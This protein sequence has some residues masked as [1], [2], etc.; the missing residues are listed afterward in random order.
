MNAIKDQTGYAGSQSGRI[1]KLSC[2]SCRSAILHILFDLLPLLRWALL[3]LVFFACSSSEPQKTATLRLNAYRDPL[4]LDPRQGS[5]MVGSALHFIL[6]EGLM[7][8]NPDGSLT[9][10]QA[11]SVKISDDRL[12]YTFHLRGTK[13]SDG[14][15][16][17]A[18][19]FEK[20][21]KKILTP[22][23]PAANAHLFACIKNGEKAKAGK[24]SVE[25]VGIVAKD[26]QTLVVTLERPTPYFLE[27]ISFCVFYPV[28]HQKDDIEKDFVSNGP[29]TLKSWKRN[30]EIVCQKNPLYWEAPLIGL[31]QIQ[32]SIVSNEA[33]VLHMYEQGEI[34]MLGLGLSPIPNE[35]MARYHKLGLLKTYSS[36]GTT[37]LSLNVSKPPFNNR[38]IRH[39]LALAINRK[40]IVE[41]VTQLGE[42]VA[43]DIIPPCLRKKRAPVYF[44]D[45]DAK[46]AQALFAKGCQELGLAQF[47]TLTYVYSSSGINHKLAQVLQQQLWETLKMSVQLRQVE[48]KVLLDMLKARSYDLAQSFW[49]AQYNDPT[50]ILERFKYSHLVKNYPGWEHPEF[51]TL[52]E[53][54]AL[55]STFERRM[56]TLESAEALLLNEMPLIPLYHWKTGFLM[57]DQFDYEEF[58]ESGFLEITRINPKHVKK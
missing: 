7:R 39:A 26:P 24:V 29:F 2:I 44:A 4:T 47:P 32:I 57:S 40:E 33:T 5:E 22:D 27:L 25:A 15:D 20:A 14:S 38:H 46:K 54:S 11:R 30:N 56:Q 19:D 28:P 10:A 36:P 18:L 49:I 58:P 17:T 37:I 42:E 51:I 6:F 1:K 52:L 23:F 3:F 16:V 53:Q 35:V 12:T 21:W 9:A 50:S 31:D 55:D 8:L 43:T 41:N 45:G 48:H 34:D 13:W